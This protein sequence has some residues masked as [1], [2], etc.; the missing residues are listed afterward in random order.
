M[1][2]DYNAFAGMTI[3]GRPSTVTVRGQVQVK[4]GQFVGDPT[5]GCF[6]KR[7]PSHF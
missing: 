6:L 4:D 3:E 2:L 1:T 7:E 5:R